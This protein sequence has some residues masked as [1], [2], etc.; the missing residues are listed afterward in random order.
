MSK[1]SASRGYL[2]RTAAGK[3]GRLSDKPL[4][5]QDAYRIIQRR[6]KAADADI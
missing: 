5:Q 1:N 4:R 2:F 6:S 3:T